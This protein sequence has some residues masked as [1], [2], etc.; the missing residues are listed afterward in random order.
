[1]NEMFLKEKLQSAGEN[2]VRSTLKLHTTPIERVSVSFCLG[3]A[4]F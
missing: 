3:S 1:M 2:L 4:P